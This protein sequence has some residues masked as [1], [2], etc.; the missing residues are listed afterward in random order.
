M[1]LRTHAIAV[2][3]VPRSMPTT[4]LLTVSDALLLVLVTPR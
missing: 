2:F 3:E 1:P 4:A